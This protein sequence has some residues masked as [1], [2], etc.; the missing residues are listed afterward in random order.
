MTQPWI[1][2]AQNVRE[3]EAAD[4]RADAVPE[5]NGADRHTHSRSIR[6]RNRD[7]ELGVRGAVEFLGPRF[8]SPSQISVAKSHAAVEPTAEVSESVERGG[9]LPANAAMSVHDVGGNGNRLQDSQGVRRQGVEQ[10][11]F[12]D[13]RGQPT[14][15]CWGSERRS[16][17]VRPSQRVSFDRLGSLPSVV[18]LSS[19]SLAKVLKRDRARE[20]H[21][22]VYSLEVISCD[23][24]DSQPR[25]K[26]A[27]LIHQCRAPFVHEVADDDDVDPDPLQQLERLE[28]IVRRQHA[29]PGIAEGLVDE[30]LDGR[31]FLQHE[32]GRRWPAHQSHADGLGPAALDPDGSVRVLRQSSAVL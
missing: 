16:S 20:S 15:P 9:V 7:L 19:C 25:L 21:A 27:K 28:R 14:L 3:P 32:D 5:R 22:V 23:A 18:K 31:V 12:S 10:I 1:P 30:L 11:R 24:D 4:D 17:R 29:V 8:A 13:R 6:T 2:L 26:R